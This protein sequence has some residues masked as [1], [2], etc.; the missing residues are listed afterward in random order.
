MPNRV[1]L[2]NKFDRDQLEAVTSTYP[3]YMFGDGL[4]IPTRSAFKV[5]NHSKVPVWKVPNGS[6]A[7]SF[8][9]KLS[10]NVFDKLGV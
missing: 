1:D 2:R 5:A 3:A 7:A 6:K 10:N 8:I 9:K 4:Y